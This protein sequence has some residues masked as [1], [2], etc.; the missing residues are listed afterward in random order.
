MIN[1][2]GLNG[3]AHSGYHELRRQASTWPRT[4]STPQGAAELLAASRDL[5]TQGYYAYTL[6]AVGGTWSIFAVEVALRSRLKASTKIPFV[7]LVKAAERQGLLPKPAWDGDRLDAGRLLRNKT[8][9][10]AGQEL[11]TPAM[12]R[13]VIESSHHAVSALFPDQ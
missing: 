7:D 13:T 9:H 11:W 12:A 3:A 8:V 5:Y 2:A 10:G 1:F 4:D 6:F